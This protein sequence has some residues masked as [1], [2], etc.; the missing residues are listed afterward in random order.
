MTRSSVDAGPDG[1]RRPCSYCCTVP[2]AKPKRRA[3]CAWVSPSLARSARSRSGDGGGHIGSASASSS[4]V[5]ASPSVYTQR[6][7]VRGIIS[8]VMRKA[9]E[10][11]LQRVTVHDRDAVVILSAEDY[12]RFAPASA[13][14]SLHAPLSSS[15]LRDLD[16][17]HGNVRSPVRDV[18]L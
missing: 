15:P 8:Q 5:H 4:S 3:N 11:G 18:E 1:R 12:V 9:R 7:E 2:S 10:Q 16:F 13:Q 14:P 17:E 6:R